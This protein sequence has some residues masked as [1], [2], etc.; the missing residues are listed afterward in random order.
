M[1]RAGADARE[2]GEQRAEACP[3]LEVA[4]QAGVGGVGVVDDGG[5]RSG[6]VCHQRVDLEAIQARRELRIVALFTLAHALL[7]LGMV[8]VELDQV[9]PVLGQR[10]S[11]ALQPCDDLVPQRCQLG[12]DRLHL[13][14]RDE[15]NDLDLLPPSGARWRPTARRGASRPEHLCLVVG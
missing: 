4:E 11:H 12:D 13:P 6:L 2:V 3:A 5:G 10:L 7:L 9:V 8:V 1:Q 15:R 14:E